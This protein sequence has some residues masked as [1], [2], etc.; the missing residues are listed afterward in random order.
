MTLLFQLQL[1]DIFLVLRAAEGL[2]VDDQVIV[3]DKRDFDIAELG[4]FLC[5]ENLSEPLQAGYCGEK[6]QGKLGS[7]QSEK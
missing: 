6:I 1:P 7:I 2:L 4:G 3:T 5:D